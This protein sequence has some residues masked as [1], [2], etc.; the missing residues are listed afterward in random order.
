MN[1]LEPPKRK[2][3]F[4][5]KSTIPILTGMLVVF[6]LTIY[7]TAQTYKASEGWLARNTLT[8]DAF[9]TAFH[10]ADYS[11][12][13]NLLLYSDFCT[14]DVWCLI[15]GCYFLYLFGGEVERR[16]G[17]T[18]FILLTFIGL[19][20]PWAIWLW[21]TTMN[22]PWM[23]I[24]GETFGKSSVAFFGPSLLTFTILG[25]YLVLATE[26]KVD[27][28]GGMP[29]PRNEIFRKK[30]EVYVA[31]RFGLNPWTF[32]SAFMIFQGAEYAYMGHFYKGVENVTLFSALGGLAFGYFFAESLLNA[33]VAGFKDG[34]LKLEAIKRYN[35]LVD[36]DVSPD[37][38]IKGTARAMGLPNEQIRDWVT[39]NK[40]RLRIS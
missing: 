19:T 14:V 10:K 7:C 11:Q 20:L 37:D 26:R 16:I 33:A 31:D 22:G 23:F 3:K 24:P 35:E 32:V 2:I 34:P 28:S 27:L 6:V 12:I 39:K 30:K 1:S 15:G 25:S 38:A 9:W 36:L 21:D 13:L 4:E 40:G 8:A 17:P 18:R 29:R 5:E